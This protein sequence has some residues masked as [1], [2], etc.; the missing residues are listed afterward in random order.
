LIF[1]CIFFCFHLLPAHGN[2]I[3]AVR[4]G[5]VTTLQPGGQASVPAGC[6][7]IGELCSVDEVLINSSS[8]GQP[9]AMPPPDAGPSLELGCSQLGFNLVQVWVR[10]ASG[11]WTA[12][13]T[14]VLLE[15]N[16][17]VCSGGPLPMQ[18]P[19]LQ[20]NLGMAYGIDGSG[21]TS[22]RASD[23]VAAYSLPQGGAPLFS[24]SPDPADSLMALTCSDIGTIPVSIYLQDGQSGMPTFVDTYAVL[25]DEAGLCA[26]GGTARSFPAYSGLVYVLPPEGQLVIR[27]AD[28]IPCCAGGDRVYAFSPD[29]SDEYFTVSCE[30]V[31]FAPATFPIPIYGIEP[32]GS[33]SVSSTYFILQDTYLYCGQGNFVP[34]N[35]DAC[36]AISLAISSPACPLIGTN[37]NATAQ[38]GEPAPPNGDCSAQYAWCDGQGAENS[39]WFSFEAPP[40]G[41]VGIRTRYFNTQL[42]LW[43]ADSCQALTEGAAIL[44]AAND[45][46]AGSSRGEAALEEI[47]CL[48]PGKTY[49]LQ[50]DGYNGESGAF[51]LLIEDLGLSC[52]LA[53][54]M[55]DCQ[56]AANTLLFPGGKIWRHAFG[57]NGGLIASIADAGNSLGDLNIQYQAH[58]G[59]IRT[60]GAG[61]PYLDRNWSIA[62]TQQPA[63]PAHLRLYFKAEEFQALQS[64]R[65]DIESPASLFLTRVPESGCGPFIA[66]GELIAQSGYGL[67]NDSDFYIDF[68]L[69][70]FSAF[71]L[72]GPEP[73][74]S[75][76]R[77]TAEE[78]PIRL[79]P[80]PAYGAV[81]L[82]LEADK[83]ASAI[84]RA[85]NAQG[86][87]VYRQ[88]VRLNKGA[89][90]LPLG[91]EGWAAGTY[92][93]HL[94]GGRLNWSGR[95]AITR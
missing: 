72:H 19:Q 43:E 15:D 1:A 81:F 70:G 20:A 90:R 14:A 95:M 31:A 28:F 57:A 67:I 39:V 21:E 82:E 73:L 48:I 6:F 38:P 53:D 25:A 7:V 88:A 62:A 74:V 16:F 60:D 54:G 51:E 84:L 83:A 92:F 2:G 40:S 55:A 76:L 58:A 11:Q 35:D 85:F 13:E 69:P 18:A 26:S 8:G 65:P 89:N 34:G 71:Y 44:V 41:S 68:S 75:G 29:P 22:L 63:G 78:S 91:V 80:N 66:G 9:G 10:T 77:S 87:E 61:Q 52:G 94:A 5:I 24:F 47:T 42:A 59:L 64:A 56:N 49:Y 4:N 30:D 36:N 12:Y 50:A 17:D 27:A 46:A 3:I 86:L 33:Y 32:D 79:S 37:I 93:V 23:F 45:D